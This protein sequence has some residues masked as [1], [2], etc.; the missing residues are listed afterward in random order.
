MFGRVV[1][2]VALCG[3]AVCAQQTRPPNIVLVFVDDLGGRD[4]GCYGNKV[5]E[6]P[7]LDRLARRGVRFTNAYAAAPVCSPTRASLMSG[8][9]PARTG[10]TDFIPGHWRPFAPLRVPTNRTQHLPLEVVT[11]AEV[12]KARGYTSGYFGKWH[13]GGPQFHPDKQGFDRTVIRTGGGHFGTRTTPDLKLGKTDEFTSAI[14]DQAARF[15]TEN[16][17]GP[18]FAMLSPYMVHIPLQG[19]KDLVEKYGERT[20]PGE[21]RHHPTYAAM[22]EHV[23]RCVGR[24]LER[25]DKLGIADNTWVVVTSDNGGLVRRFS[26]DRTWVSTNA[27][28][29]SEKGSLYEGGIRVPLIVVGPGARAG[30]T[31]DEPVITMDLHPTFAALGGAP[32]SEGDG[33]SLVPLLTGKGGLERDALFWHY[34]HYHHHTPA[35][36][37]RY[38]R[39]RLIVTWE[40]GAAQLFDL[41]ADP[42]E[43][44]D[45]ARTRGELVS[46]LRKRL[47]AQLGDAALPVKN[48]DHDPEK[49]GRWGRH[50]SRR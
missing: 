21:G 46:E 3:A 32:R 13:L 9:S 49:A 5:I 50:P 25:I 30:V 8:R 22:V 45:L 39:W 16:K 15:M 6:T 4:L 48:P 1:L 12:L 27:P 36:A 31:C 14:V 42:S 10:I 33:K 24:L 29:R 41:G 18:F 23:D 2:I 28:L 26:G 40:D 34:P 47:T 19:P 44:R 7:H 17:D 20:Q 43:S 37:I 38:G 35:S 11:P